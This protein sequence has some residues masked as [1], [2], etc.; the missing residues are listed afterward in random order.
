MLFQQ[1]AF[2]VAIVKHHIRSYLDSIFTVGTLFF[3]FLIL[4]NIREL[5][6]SNL[7]SPIISLTEEI[8]MALNEEFKVIRPA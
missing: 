4:Q 1:L 7:L 6:D 2:L 8:S 3:F 5:W